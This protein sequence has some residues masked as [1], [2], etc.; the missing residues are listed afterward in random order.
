MVGEVVGLS[1]REEAGLPLGL[2][3]N[4]EAGLPL[5]LSLNEEAGLPL[6]LSLSEEAGLPWV[7]C[8]IECGETSSVRRLQ[9]AHCRG[10]PIAELWVLCDDQ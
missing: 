9:I 10:G 5:G 8:E 2:S 6:G 3:L 7:S 4:E 1:L